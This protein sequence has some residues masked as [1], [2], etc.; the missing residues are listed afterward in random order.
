[1]DGVAG[2]SNLAIKTVNTVAVND[3]PALN[4][5]LNP[6][7]TTIA[8]DAPNPASTLVS[9]LLTGAVTDPDPGALRGIAVY[10]AWGTNGT[11]Q[12]TLNGGGTWQ[13][14]GNVS[15]TSARLLPGWA[16]IRLLPKQDFNGSVTLNYRAWDQTQG[17]TGGTFN[18][19]GNIGGTKAFSSAFESAALSVMPVNDKP[20]LT[21]SGTIGYVHDHAAITLASSATVS[22]VD[23][24]DFANGRLRVRITDGAGAANRLAIGAG[25]TVDASNNNVLLGTTIIGKRTSN[26]FGTTELIVVFKTG[27]SPSVVQQL[28]RA[29]TFQTVGGSAGTRKIVFSVSDGNGGLSDEATKTVNVT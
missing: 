10:G 1:L 11:W 15:A 23:S 29:I 20:V 5:A 26:G 28:V 19:T 13:A 17:T 24:N 7:L 12:Y 3:A 9:S 8:E 18:L 2:V 25:F 14:M 4:D 6:T 27:A 16:G 21:L 22:D